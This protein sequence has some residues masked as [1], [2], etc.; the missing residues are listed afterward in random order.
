MILAWKKMLAVSVS[1]GM[2]LLLPML[3]ALT[4]TPYSHIKGV[5]SHKIVSD[6]SCFTS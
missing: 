2:L 3:N 4:N 1:P 5:P 6:G